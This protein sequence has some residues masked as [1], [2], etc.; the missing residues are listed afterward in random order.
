MKEARSLPA[1]H[2]G[3]DGW[4]WIGRHLLPLGQ[5]QW[6]ITAEEAAAAAWGL[7]WGQKEEPE[8]LSEASHIPGHI[9]IIRSFHWQLHYSKSHIIDF[10]KRYTWG[11]FSLPRK[12]IMS[13]RKKSSSKLQTG[14]FS[15]KSIIV[16]QA[17]VR[18]YKVFATFSSFLSIWFPSFQVLTPPS[19]S[20]SSDSSHFLSKAVSKLQNLVC[21]TPI[22]F[23]FVQFSALWIVSEKGVLNKFRWKWPVTWF[24]FLK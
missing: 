19:S 22:G 1:S 17:T 9:Q 2:H 24:A 12:A 20:Q 11:F 14:H 6:W 16:D 3:Q 18:Y 21:F 23:P 5:A 7:P 4:H 8:K 13:Q 10:G 15:E